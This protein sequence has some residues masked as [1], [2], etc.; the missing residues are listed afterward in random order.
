METE[1][2]KYKAFLSYSRKDN[3]LAKKLHKQLENYKIPK[4][5]YEE[6]PNL[7]SKLFPTFWALS[8]SQS[9]I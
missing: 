9:L 3:K 4:D 8:N 5:L 1:T 2:Y 6:Y 7:P